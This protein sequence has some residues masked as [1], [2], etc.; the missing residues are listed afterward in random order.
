MNDLIAKQIGPYQVALKIHETP[1]RTLYRAFDH[2]LGREVTL[3][4]VLPGRAFTQNF[5]DAIKAQARILAGLKQV[6]IAPLLDCELYGDLLCLVFDIVPKSILRKPLQQVYSWSQAASLLVPVAQA[7]T[8]AHEKGVAHQSLS[9]ASILVSR[10]GALYLFDFGI[11]RII[12]QQLTANAPGLWVG[13]ANAHYMAPELVLQKTADLRADIYS[14][15]MVYYELIF[16]SPLYHKDNLIEDLRRQAQPG[17]STPAKQILSALPEPV[18]LLIARA[19]NPEPSRRFRSMLEVSVLFTRIALGHKLTAGMVR[20]PLRVIRPPMKPAVKR[21]IAA[22]LILL[23]L[24]AAGYQYRQPIAQF[25]LALLPEDKPAVVE[26]PSTPAA[27]VV[28]EKTA[29]PTSTPKRDE[30]ERQP[31][32]MPTDEQ[33]TGEQRLP[34]LFGTPLPYITNSMNTSNTARTM[35]L[36]RWG[37]G[38]FTDME[39]SPND[40]TIALATTVGIFIVNRTNFAVLQ[41]IDTVTDIVSVAFSPD[42]A[43]LATGERDGLIRVWDLVSGEEHLSLGGHTRQVNDV[44][45]SPDGHYIAS[46]SDDNTIRVWEARDGYPLH[47]LTGHVQ[48]ARAVAFSPDS[49]VLLSGGQDFTLIAWNHKAGALISKRSAGGKIND[50]Q[51][52]PNGQWVALAEESGRVE[53]YDLL[54][55]QSKAQLTGLAAPTLSVSIHPGGEWV[56]GADGNGKTMVWDLAKTELFSASTRRFNRILNTGAVYSHAVRFTHDG[57]H[58]ISANWDNTFQAWQTAGWKETSSFTQAGFFTTRMA[59]S[60]Y[61][62]L[63]A[64]QRVNDTIDVFDLQKSAFI[65]QLTGKIVSDRSFSSDDKYLAVLASPGTVKVYEART[66]REIYTF[67][68]HSNVNDL[69]FSNNGKYLAAGTSTDLHLWSMNSGQEIKTIVNYGV[70][71]CTVSYNWQELPVTYTTGFQWIDFFAD[72]KAS[73]CQITRAGWMTHLKLTRSLTYAA[74]AGTSRIQT[75]DYDKNAAAVVMNDTYGYEI[76]SLAISEKGDLVAAAMDDLSIRLYDASTGNEL[77]RLFG[78]TQP[79]TSIVFT[80]DTRHL[81]TAALDGSIFLWGVR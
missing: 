33:P 9:L 40:Q 71:G 11:D 66:G 48:P 24:L 32:V 10:E 16:G 62:S 3:M 56:A 45:F 77:V 15:G 49:S 14:F 69:Q 23:A 37:M 28:A 5:V 6:S 43:M 2:K 39:I 42:G 74:A 18:R 73:L 58:L 59:V 64:V 70:S 75:W 38:K 44:T 68:G 21:A 53:L 47:V 35:L 51:Y 7:L 81:I 27:A 63:L 72:R 60:P 22:A 8:Y 31:T 29:A 50:I 65:Y 13:G 20:R 46:A 41:H 25:A 17:I 1:T 4:I 30:P 67:N 26:E 57:I 55:N 61:S 19:I 76:Q 78:H 52:F 34:V 12:Y 80:P 36:S 54:E 79:I